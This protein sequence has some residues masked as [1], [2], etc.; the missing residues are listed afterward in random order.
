MKWNNNLCQ[1]H[2]NGTVGECPYCGSV[3][4]DYAYAEKEEGRAYLDVWCNSCNE[5]VHVDCRFVPE[6]LKHMSV[7][8][9]VAV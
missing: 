8:S 4:T 7:A 9:A 6:N 2:K 1:I 3:N 5:Q